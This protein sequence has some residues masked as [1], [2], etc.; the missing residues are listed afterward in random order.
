MN[1]S[2]HS[3]IT[4]YIWIVKRFSNFLLY[5]PSCV[6]LINALY[7]SFAGEK[8]SW[9][10]GFIFVLTL[11]AFAGYAMNIV[12]RYAAI[13]AIRDYGNRFSF[14]LVIPLGKRYKAWR[15]LTFITSIIFGITAGSYMIYATPETFLCGVLVLVSGIEKLVYL[16]Y[17]S[18]KNYFRLGVSSNSIILCNGGLQIIPLNGLN[19][20]ETKY[21]ELLFIY[22]DNS[23]KSIFYPVSENALQE[24]FESRLYELGKEKGFGLKIRS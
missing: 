21:D 8:Y 22:T 23:V 11:V 16:V 13:S 15:M 10:D 7:L 19:K 24:A 5:F 3:P 17:G 14:S 9:M 12:D 4:Y 18:T 6:V 1:H 20:V 2:S